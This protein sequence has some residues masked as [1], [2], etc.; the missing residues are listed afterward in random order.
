MLDKE[1]WCIVRYHNTSPNRTRDYDYIARKVYQWGA[2][3]AH[4]ENKWEYVARGLTE[5]QAKEYSK[6]FKE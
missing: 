5:K 4:L 1:E 6:L 2:V 3:G